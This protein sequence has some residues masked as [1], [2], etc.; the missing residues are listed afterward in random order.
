MIRCG[1]IGCGVIS[2]THLA[3]Y[4]QIPGVEVTGF[5][6]LILPR[7][8]KLAGSCPGARCFRDYHELLETVDAVSV[9][10]DHASHAEIVCGAIEA[11]R[12]VICEK[13]L[14]RVPEDLD[15][16]LAAATAHPEVVASG[17]FQHR[18]N[19]GNIALREA[20]RSGRLGKLLTVGLNFACLRDAS[21][22]AKDG[23]RGTVA[24]EGGGVLI[25]QS[26]HFLDQL[27]F[28]FGDIVRV[29][30]LSGNFT[31]GDAIEVE[32]TAAAVGETEDGVPITICA[33][34]SAS[35]NWRSAMTVTGSRGRIELIDEKVS[36]VFAADEKEADAIRAGLE[37]AEGDDVV[38]GKCYYGTGH[39]AQLADFIEA[40]RLHRAPSVTLADAAGSAALVHAIYAAAATGSWQEVRRFR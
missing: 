29:A 27:R 19:P 33:T 20:V 13:V 40:V 10:T 7:A 23:W 28:L 12:H 8:E 2:G 35:V 11:G 18:F 17:I 4:R 31:H 14:G 24:G 36:A 9:C 15:M 6:D 5:C 1:I 16:M 38:H 37:S 3:G 21:Y 22:Y 34:N 30:A 32:D 25:N 26:I 39:T